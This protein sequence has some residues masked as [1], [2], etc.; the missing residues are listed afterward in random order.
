[1]VLSGV[2]SGQI[3]KIKLSHV[4]FSEEAAN[5]VRDL[6]LLGHVGQ[7]DVIPQFEEAFA[8]WVGSKYA[9]AVANGTLADTIALAALA[10]KRPGRP[11][12]IMPALTFAAQVNAVIH[13]G[14]RPCFV[15]VLPNLLMNVNDPRVN[16]NQHT[17]CLF[18]VHLLGRMS[19]VPSYNSKE[20]PVIEDAC[21][22]MGS[23][24]RS[25]KAGTWGTMGTF[26]FFPSHT[27]TTGEGGMI[28]TN[29]PVL[30][31]VCRRLRNHAKLSQV[32]FHF[33][34]VG[35]NGKMTSMQAMLGLFA[36]KGIEAVISARRDNYLALGGEETEHEFVCPHGFP[37]MCD[38]EYSRD[39]MLKR[40][41]DNGI[42]CRNIFSS[43]PT[44]EISYRS[45]GYKRGDFPVAEHIG[46][47]GLYVPVHQ[48]LK[49]EDIKKIKEIIN[50]HE[51]KREERAE[52]ALLTV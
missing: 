10:S 11:N 35:W 40:L 22:A 17:L 12:V 23:Q 48:G 1:M 32:N 51:E 3:N 50:H 28:V 7:S 9:I 47:V 13:A 43:L 24:F 15:D 38:D 42:E 27:I 6:I 21:E 2:W 44:Q 8:A 30:A 37:I 20:I 45:L 46:R 36:L 16:I 49:S 33:D 29:D 14:L 19:T 5:A 26:S 52:K 31:D 34:M 25:R 41:N 4:E 18:P 39:M